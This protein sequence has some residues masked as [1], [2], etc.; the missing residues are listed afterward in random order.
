[1]EFS[2]EMQHTPESFKALSHMQYD[3]FCTSNLIT[4]TVLGFLCLV[5]GA[6]NLETWW[7]VLLGVY[8]YY[9][10][11]SKYASS[12]HTANKLTAQLEAAG[13]PFPA[14]RFCFYGDRVDIIPLP[15][16]AGEVSSLAYEDFFGMGE[17]ESYIYFFRNQY[18]GYM[19][20]KAAMGSD[21]AVFRRF[22]RE[23]TGKKIYLKKVPP[24]L[25]VL[26]NLSQRSTRRE[27]PPHL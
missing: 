22:L 25:R 8:G 6:T 21:E 4:R 9:L 1:M 7:G 16:E 13:M 2:Y 11:S 10:I 15:E 23:K 17:D 27:E 19:I 12:N 5:T 14:S 3:L 26:N 24:V 18:G 20:P